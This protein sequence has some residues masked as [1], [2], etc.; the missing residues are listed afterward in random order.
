[1][2]R[3]FSTLKSNKKNIS[4]NILVFSPFYQLDYEDHL[5]AFGALI[6][7]AALETVGASET[8]LMKHTL[9]N[10]GV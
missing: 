9:L 6:V 3:L 1:M 2:T 5:V 8:S 7:L 4:L 10:S